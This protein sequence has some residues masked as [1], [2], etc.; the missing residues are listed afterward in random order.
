MPGTPTNG[1][2]NGNFVVNLTTGAITVSSTVDGGGGLPPG[3]GHG[4]VDVY[5]ICAP[6]SQ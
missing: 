2:D 6:A 4:S 1:A 5:Q 3:S